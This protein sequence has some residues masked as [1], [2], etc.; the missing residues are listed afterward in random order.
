MSAKYF[1]RSVRNS[2]AKFLFD[3]LKERDSHV[4]ISHK[5]MPTY[6]S[7]LKFIESKPY[8]K[9]YVI[10]TLDDLRSELKSSKTKIGSIYLSKN[11]EV[12]IFILKKFQRKNVGKYALT[13]LMKRNPRS[14]YL[15]NVNPKNKKSMQ[16]FKNNSFKLIQYTF[17]LSNNS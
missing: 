17:E 4:N 3:L 10:F 11:N 1:M 14:R 5:K 15:A 9:W 16:F 8:K 6:T 12:G 2:D 7:H 13:E